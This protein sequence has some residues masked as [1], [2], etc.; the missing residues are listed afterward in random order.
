MKNFTEGENFHFLPPFGAAM[1]R[2]KQSVASGCDA[3]GVKFWGLSFYGFLQSLKEFQIPKLNL[4]R[5]PVAVTYFFL[6]FFK[7]IVKFLI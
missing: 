5:Y 2:K 3:I 1:K 6:I 7:P 4:A